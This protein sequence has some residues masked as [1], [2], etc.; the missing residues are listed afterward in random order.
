MLPQQAKPV[1]LC[2]IDNHSNLVELLDLVVSSFIT[3]IAY[4]YPR[5]GP[6]SHQPGFIRVANPTSRFN[7]QI[8]NIW[9]E[10]E[11][12]PHAR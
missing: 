10:Q 1:E 12:S 3:F 7:F 5:P 6:Q 11:G 4:H 9:V 2:R 8:C